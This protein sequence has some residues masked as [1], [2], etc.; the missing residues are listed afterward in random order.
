MLAGWPGRADG[1]GVHM[2]R[3]QATDPAAVA[4]TLIEALL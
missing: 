1:L 4:A 3:L 2:T